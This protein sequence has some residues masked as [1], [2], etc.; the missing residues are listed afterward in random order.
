VGFLE[1]KNHS[2][3]PS[4][5]CGPK[6]LLLDSSQYQPIS[7]EKSLGN[8]PCFSSSYFGGTSMIPES[9]FDEW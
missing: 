1:D 7:A 5:K 3:P 2:G 9:T 6:K 4:G 8:Y